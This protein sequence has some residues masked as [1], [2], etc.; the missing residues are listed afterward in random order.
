MLFHSPHVYFGDCS[1]RAFFSIA[2]NDEFV[3][4]K[5]ES[6]RENKLFVDLEECFEK[7]RQSMLGNISNFLLI[8]DF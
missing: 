2:P 4:V 3:F 1:S 5:A 7:Q 8:Y 6:R